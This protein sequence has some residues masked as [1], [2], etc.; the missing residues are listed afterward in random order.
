MEKEEFKQLLKKTF[1]EG[2]WKH[3]EDSDP[4]AVVWDFIQLVI[5]KLKIKTEPEKAVRR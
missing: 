3:K 2:K 1:K 5:H 4:K